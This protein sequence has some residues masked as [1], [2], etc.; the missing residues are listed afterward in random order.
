MSAE[1]GLFAVLNLVLVAVLVG[2]TIY[3]A[4]QTKATVD[5]LREARIAEFLPLLHWQDPSL[6]G[7]TTG[8]GKMQLR[9]GFIVRNAGRGPARLSSFEASV[10]DGTIAPLE[11]AIPSTVPANEQF[12][13]QTL[14]HRQYTTGRFPVAITVRYADIAK[15]RQYET[16]VRV[17]VEVNA[18]SDIRVTDFDSDER[19]ADERRVTTPA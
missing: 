12:R 15:L 3:Y 7:S 4:R 5:E 19:S 14:W 6:G 13:L 9:L 11:L 2:A 8:E 10:P 18:L 16:T 17:T 1:Q